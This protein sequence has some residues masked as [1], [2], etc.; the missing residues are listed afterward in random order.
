MKR[1]K[2]QKTIEE[3]HDLYLM[4]LDT[5]L[6]LNSVVND[7]Y[8][9]QVVNQQY[10]DI[11][12]KPKDY[13][14]GR[15]IADIVGNKEFEE[16]IKPLIDQ[17]LQ[18]E[19]VN[20][21]Y[22]I[23]YPDHDER[24]VFARYV[25]I[26]DKSGS[27]TKVVINVRDITEQKQ[28]DEALKE[29]EKK[30]RNLL[31][32]APDGK[33]IVNAKGKI[34]LVNQQLMKM[35]GYTTGDLVGQLVEVLIPDRFKNHKQH[36]GSYTADP[37]VRTMGEG[38]VLFV[39]CKD[40]SEFPAEINLS[41][42]ETK[43]G[44]IVSTD[45]RDIT[46]RKQAEDE[47]RKS[48]TLYGKAEKMGKL[49]YW[50]WDVLADRLIACSEQYARIFEM[51]ENDMQTKH[52][53]LDDDLDLIHPD[54][55]A[56]YKEI[57]HV[58]DVERKNPFDIEYRI[59]TRTGKVRYVHE[60]GDPVLNKN[61]DLVRTYGFIQDIT[62]RKLAEEELRKNQILYGQAE[63]MGKLGYWEWTEKEDRLIICS[64]EFARIYEM[65]V[66]EALVFFSNKTSEINVV[67]PDD[68]RRYEQLLIDTAK[69]REGMDIEFRIITQSGKIRHVHQ[70][71]KKVLDNKG[72]IIGSFG[73][74]QDITDR[75]L[76]EEELRK[77]HLLYSQAEQMGKLG[78]WEWDHINHRMASC[79]KEFARSYGMTV[80]EAK[81]FF[82]SWENEL[83]VVHPDDRKRYEQ[84]ILKSEEH[85]EKIDIEFRIVTP[86]GVER[87]AHLLG[88]FVTDDEGRLITSFGAEQDITE[89]K[90]AEKQLR[91][92]ASHDT[93]TGLVNRYE[94]ERRAERLLSSIGQEKMEHALCYMDLDQFKVVNDTCGHTAGDELLR[95]LGAALQN[96]VRKRDTLAR[97]GGDEFGVLME[98]CSL[99]QAQR[100][101]NSLQKAI[102]DYQFTWENQSFRVGVSIG[103]VTITDATPSL[104]ELMKQADAACYIAKDKGRNRIHV[105]HA[106]DIELA[107]R[108]GEMQW[109]ARLHR[110]L[111]E[112]RFCLYAQAIVPLD[113]SRGLHYELL[114]RMVDE[115][116][117]LIPPDA[118]LPAAE[119][120]NLIVDIDRWVIE[121]GI[122][123][124]AQNPVFQ[125]QIQFISINLSGHS[126]TTP[127]VLDFITTQLEVSGIETNK[128]CF[129][130]T[131]TAAIANLSM[132]TNFISTLR[133]LGCRF[134]LDDFGSGLSSFAYLKNLPVDYLKIDGMFVKDIVV[135][136]IDHA[137]VKSINEIGQVLGMQTIAE[138]V[139]N[140][141]IKG[142]LREIGV[143][144]AQGYGID[145]PQIFDELLARFK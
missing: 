4:V 52:A 85:Q 113:S 76:A 30:Y 96:E 60:M 58:N 24:F 38:L 107:Q 134:A 73:T 32:S 21:E 135:D 8:V 131:E 79:S 70:M 91:F 119:R 83:S 31:E 65:T 51:S 121:K 10:A 128:I 37:Y 77:S 106:D 110:A 141:E 49:G 94:F 136:P 7:Q 40:G 69:Q 75:K 66:D 50:E 132:A 25:P 59:I 36:R 82:S 87:Y 101:A 142:L 102:Q 78:H 127:G 112:N 29:S 122:T 5:S 42:L 48:H 27:V 12:N 81:E 86:S 89:R 16:K 62:D 92:Q 143:N 104:T 17:C 71:S 88:E 3:E 99:D 72:K 123:V 114:L 117:K 28:A 105:H 55:R 108:H 13:F 45:I 2:S 124:L 95:Q 97:L 120:Y 93:L 133:G 129:E 63:Q 47:L 26:K 64:E 80:D 19:E 11:F 116:G 9:Y 90:Q 140:D 14:I 23:E 103:L 33:V 74:E 44:L 41:P 139:E 67:H 98:H 1:I 118:F 125:Q 84:C 68:R 53:N 34:E 56:R 22:W 18:G 57:V 20:S 100:V 126:L 35:T 130:I 54:D 39:Q 144:Y 15:T 6:N 61:G 111:E 115:K 138:F 109:V 46:K 137:M 43:E 145:K